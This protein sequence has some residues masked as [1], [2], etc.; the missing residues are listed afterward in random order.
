MVQLRDKRLPPGERASLARRVVEVSHRHGA[1]V[2][3]NGDETFARALG[4]DGVHW[5]A[6]RLM[7]ATARPAGLLC[8]ASCHSLQELERAAELDCDL[9]VVG[10]V[11]DTASHP[12]ADTLGWD[13][14]AR[15]T[16]G[17]R[18][19][20]FAIGGVQPADLERAWTCGGHGLAMIRGSWNLN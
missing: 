13:G 10:P 5:P 9:A 2:L 4:A 18:L 20:I 14:F 6:D 16:L 1:R 7:C 3:V 15:L 19:P 12:G 8:A 11:L 17:A